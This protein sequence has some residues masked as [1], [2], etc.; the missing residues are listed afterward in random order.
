MSPISLFFAALLALG[1][2]LAP[3]HYLP[4]VAFHGEWMMA[5]AL[6][7][8][9]AGELVTRKPQAPDTLS[10]FA[11]GALAL[12]VV[13]LLQAASGLILLSGDAWVVTLYLIGFALAFWLGQRL[14]ARLGA[15]RLAEGL[16]LVFVTGSVL[17]VGLQ[18]LQW[19]QI[20][21]L[22]IFRVD[23]PPWGRPFANF[24]QPNHLATLLLLGLAGVALL[25][26]RRRIGPAGAALAALFIAFGM[27]ATGSRT[28]WVALGLLA[29][30]ALL[31]RRRLALRLPATAIVA[32]G[33]AFA[34]MVLAW[35]PLNEALLLS[36]GRSLANQAQVGPRPLFFATM[37]DA[38]S[39][40][41]WFGYGWNQGLLAQQHVLEAHPAG[42]RLMGNAHNMVLDLMVWNGIPLGLAIA[43]GIAAWLVRQ[44]RGAR[45]VVQ[46]FLLAAVGGVF[47]HAMFEY[48]LSYAYFLL[49]VGVM[50]GALD[51]LAPPR[52]QFALP[53]FVMPSIAGAAAALLAL[54]TVEYAEVEANTRTLA[55]ETARIG[56]SRIESVAPELRLL[57]QWREYLRF[58]RIEPG[59][60]LPAE[61]IV[62]MTQLTERFPYSPSMLRLAQAQALNGDPAAAQ[63]TLARLCLLHSATRCRDAVREWRQLARESYPQLAAVPLPARP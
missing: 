42:G 7:L 51:A 13:P 45:D 37:L 39:R 33:L 55:F 5:V 20:V 52:R 29:L 18:L 44:L 2:W 9:V 16:A 24:A 23:M 41:P 6:A 57:T 38:I 3:N 40:Q 1:A 60:G 56:H 36:G 47:V 59:P 58:A 15:A 30:G 22:G 53:R 46:G 27:A 11:L 14:V 12:A 54:L 35:A 43:A 17:S 63:R 61:Q 31:A 34:A 49:P 62:W 21:A 19:L 32:L 25:Y 8:A 26:E 4:W 28:A 10:L 50:M 48:P